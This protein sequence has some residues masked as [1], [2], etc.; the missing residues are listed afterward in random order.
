MAEARKP[1]KKAKAA[2]SP[3]EPGTTYNLS[4][5]CVAAGISEPTLYRWLAVEGLRKHSTYIGSKW[6]I[7][8][9]QFSEWIESKS[10]DGPSPETKS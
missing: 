7:T 4:D 1:S 9:K 5:F 2:S 8:G 10:G 6:F 3:I